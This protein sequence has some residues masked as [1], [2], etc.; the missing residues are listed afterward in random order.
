MA[1]ETIQLE[2]FNN[3]LNG[4]R[5]LCQGLFTAKYPSLIEYIQ[6]LRNPFKKKILLSNTSFHLCK[7][8]PLHYDATFQVKDSQDW[9]LILTYITYAPKPLLVVAEDINVPDGL[10]NKMNRSTTFVNF[11]NSPINKI[12]KLYSYDTIFFS[13]IQE[14]NTNYTEYVYKVLQGLYRTNYTMNEH[15]EIVNELRVA[16]AGIV[17]NRLNEERTT[18]SIYWYDPVEINSSDRL[19]N[20]QLSELLGFLSDQFKLKE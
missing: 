17:W 10:W 6:Q 8:L 1:Q 9:T 19:S 18:G 3:D 15:K 20:K 7:Y 4:A 14:I 11:S 16:S 13:P 12:A 2:A 5:I